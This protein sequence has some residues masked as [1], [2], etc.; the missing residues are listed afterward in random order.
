MYR[1]FLFIVLL[2]ATHS[3]IG[4]NIPGLVFG[5]SNNDIGTAICQTEDEGFLLVG[6][7]RSFGNGSEDIYL[8]KLNKF[9]QTQWEETTG[10]THRDVIRSVIEVND[11]FLMAG[12][13]WDIGLSRSEVYL[14]KTSKNG[15]LLWRK[16][17]GT[18]Q[19]ERGFDFIK[20]TDNYLYLLGYSR[21]YDNRGDVLLIK[22]DTSGN[23]I[24]RSSFGYEYD[25]YGM[26]LIEDKNGDIV[27]IGSRDGFFDDVHVNYKEHDADFFLAKLNPQGQILWKKSFG[28]NEHDFGYGILNGPDDT[29]YISGSTQT[30]SNGKFD[31]FLANTDTAG[32]ILWQTNFGGE[33]Y[34][35]C[36]SI[37]KNSDEDLFL[38]GT[39]KSFSNSADIYL[40]KTNPYGEEIWS[41]TIDGDKTDYGNNI[42]STDDGGCI[43]IGQSQDSLGIFNL[44]ITKINTHGIIEGITWK[45]KNPV[46]PD[47]AFGPNPMRNKGNF[48][49]S[50]NTKLLV[51]ITNINGQTIET[52]SIENGETTF[53]RG[54]L[55]AGSY[56]Y[57][58]L[59]Q[60]EETVFFRGKIVIQ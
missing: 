47:I 14:Q 1:F 23:E 18:Q 8:I 48:F 5:G 46:I 55:S 30:N 38:V 2:S 9:F 33:N 58:I 57:S 28:G 19:N 7:T 56:I 34:E 37:I 43:V 3:L 16:G 27:I 49:Y 26:G 36:V 35:Y 20:S 53:N 39:T 4:Q 17:Y 21:G 52:F 45:N 13:A 6:T 29:Y 60:T 11:G 12:D 54:G 10:K 24:W 44:V 25:D 41:L 15:D 51:K 59:N 50:G 31:M 40:I 32:N 22:T 42:I